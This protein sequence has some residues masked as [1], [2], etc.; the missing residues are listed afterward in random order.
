ML[1]PQ[2]WTSQLQAVIPDIIDPPDTHDSCEFTEPATADERDPHTRLTRQVL[3]QTR[4]LFRQT[5]L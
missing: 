2:R 1:I 3:Q 4:G 5:G